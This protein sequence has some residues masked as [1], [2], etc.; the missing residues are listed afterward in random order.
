MATTNRCT[1]LL[2]FIISIKAL[3]FLYVHTQA[4]SSGLLLEHRRHLKIYNHTTSFAAYMSV[5]AC[6][7]ALFLCKLW[8]VPFLQW[9][10]S[11]QSVS[12]P[13]NDDSESEES[14]HFMD[15]EGTIVDHHEGIANE[16][17]L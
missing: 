16:C 6:M 7:C 2:L 12:K 17:T 9:L 15:V 5:I 3:A 14:V 1:V 8:N 13:E 4:S 10:C 11:R